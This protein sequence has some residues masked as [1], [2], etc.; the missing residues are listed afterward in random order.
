MAR[1]LCWFRRFRLQAS[2]RF[3]VLCEPITAVLRTLRVVGGNVE[4]WVKRT[5]RSGALSRD[6]NC[7]PPIR[8]CLLKVSPNGRGWNLASCFPQ[9]RLDDTHARAAEI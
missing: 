4:C 5:A 6:S 7:I 2:A 9:A 3:F 1:T 8:N